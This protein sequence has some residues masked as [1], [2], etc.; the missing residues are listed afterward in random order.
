MKIID[1]R[2]AEQVELSKI[3]TGSPFEYDGDVYITGYN[4]TGYKIPEF[5]DDSDCLAFDVATGEVC[6]FD[7]TM[8]VT[9]VNASIVVE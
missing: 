2:F 4:A 5:K 9:P 7:R 6:V 8:F 3:K 1:K